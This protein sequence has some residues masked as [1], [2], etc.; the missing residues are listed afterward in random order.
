MPNICLLH[1]PHEFRRS[2]TYPPSRA[3][4]AVSS[5]PLPGA[6]QCSAVQCVGDDGVFRAHVA[7]GH[8]GTLIVVREAGPSHACKRMRRAAGFGLST[9]MTGDSTHGE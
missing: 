8:S 2:L 1:E 9:E 3:G 5:A 4:P 7:F 6:K